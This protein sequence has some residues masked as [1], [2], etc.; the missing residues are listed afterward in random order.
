MSDPQEEEQPRTDMCEEEMLLE[1]DSA[2][3]DIDYHL[4][5]A[6]KNLIKAQHYS[7]KLSK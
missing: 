1:L 3:I 6:F 2:L 4:G 7:E 5:Q